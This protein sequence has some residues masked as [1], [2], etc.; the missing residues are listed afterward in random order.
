MPG[1]S[2]WSAPVMTPCPQARATW[3]RGAPEDEWVH[4]WTG[5]GAV[6]ALYGP[7]AM[8]TD[9]TKGML[10]DGLVSKTKA[11]PRVTFSVG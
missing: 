10:R 11:S 3:T 8:A 4:D 7:G 5:I 2:P 6:G 9:G 1:S